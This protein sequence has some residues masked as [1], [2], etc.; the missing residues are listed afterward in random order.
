MN[1]TRYCLTVVI[2]VISTY[3]N[4]DSEHELYL[5][6]YNDAFPEAPVVES[7]MNQIFSLVDQMAFP[8]RSRA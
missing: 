1:D 3:F 2:T 7:R 6:K 8:P 4:R 5:E